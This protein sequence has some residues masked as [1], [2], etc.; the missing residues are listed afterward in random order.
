L[1]DI[2]LTLP[3]YKNI[4]L[5][6]PNSEITILTKKQYFDFFCSIKEID[7]I[8][9]LDGI[10]KTISLLKNESFNFLI[11]LHSNLRSFIFRKLIN[12]DK[13]IRYDKDAIYRRIF[14]K[15]KVAMP[16]LQKHTVDRYLETLSKINIPIVTDSISIDDFQFEIIKEKNKI[17]PCK[18][19][20]VQTAFLGDSLLTFLF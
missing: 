10:L 11:D 18:I 17:T 13:K 19:L 5:K 15:F 3:V 4:K 16:S 7:R 9:V 20:V 6:Y 1:G 12:A 2:L 8:I 14:V